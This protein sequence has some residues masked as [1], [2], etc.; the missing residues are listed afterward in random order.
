MDT[1]RCVVILH[2]C[3]FVSPKDLSESLLPLFSS[4]IL[5]GLQDVD[6]DVRAVA[7]S[8]LLPVANQLHRVLSG[9]VPFYVLQHFCSF[10][11]LLEPSVH[12][13]SLKAGG[14]YQNW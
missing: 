5:R 9:K 10:I 13:N 12:N 6:Y 8:A 7:A 11:I 14:D 3:L 1:Y 4:S 2:K